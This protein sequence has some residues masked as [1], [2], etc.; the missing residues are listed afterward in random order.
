MSLHLH[1]RGQEYLAL[2]SNYQMK[3]HLGLT[4]RLSGPQYR[5]RWKLSAGLFLPALPSNAL[6]STHVGSSFLKGSNNGDKLQSAQKPKVL[7]A[8]RS[9]SAINPNS[10]PS[11]T[12]RVTLLEPQS[13]E[14][15]TAAVTKC[16][17]QL[18]RRET[19]NQFHWAGIRS[20]QT[21]SILEAPGNVC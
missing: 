20:R 1:Q 4:C 18:W 15:P 7:T 3:W 9:A 13:Y 10:L 8:A 21:A 11:N 6:L 12:V 19:Q 16:H 2:T 5:P 14:F 17:K